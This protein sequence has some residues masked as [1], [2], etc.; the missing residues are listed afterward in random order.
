[1]EVTPV[2]EVA[3]TQAVCLGH[4]LL[5]VCETSARR[6]LTD[7]VLKSGRLSL[8]DTVLKSGRLSLMN[9]MLKTWSNTTGRYHAQNVFYVSEKGNPG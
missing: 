6:T 4:R 7:T 9:T 5:P 2:E 3:C 1:M 8:T